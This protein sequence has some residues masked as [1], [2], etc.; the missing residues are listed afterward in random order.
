ML[1]HRKWGSWC[2]RPIVFVA[3]ARE[4]C[5]VGEDIGKPSY[6]GACVHLATLA[7]IRL[8]K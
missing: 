3:I 7:L 2:L 6:Y 8:T 4:T 1:Q 5:E